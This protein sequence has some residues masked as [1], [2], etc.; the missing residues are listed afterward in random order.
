MNGVWSW[1]TPPFH[2]FSS[3]GVLAL[4]SNGMSIHAHTPPPFARPRTVDWD[5][6]WKSQ[7]LVPAGKCFLYWKSGYD[8]KTGQKLGYLKPGV[9][10]SSGLAASVPRGERLVEA[11]EMNVEE[12]GV[13]KVKATVEKK[14]KKRTEE[15]MIARMMGKKKM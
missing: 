9:A 1:A 5:K 14:K 2:G 13:G 10:V 11:E 7:G 8:N 12:D 6:T 15:D 3:S 4:I